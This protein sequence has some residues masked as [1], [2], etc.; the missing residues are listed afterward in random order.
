M[1]VETGRVSFKE[2]IANLARTAWQVLKETGIRE[3][4]KIE[5]VQ[6]EVESQKTVMG[7][8]MLWKIFPI[9]AAVGLTLFLVGRFK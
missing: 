8:E 1:S 3:T 2:I 7:K 4:A 5:L 6:R 9:A